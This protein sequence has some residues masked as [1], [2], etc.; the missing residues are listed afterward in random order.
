MPDF[1]F[2]GECFEA[3]TSAFQLVL[4]SC[5]LLPALPQRLNDNILTDSSSG[6]KHGNA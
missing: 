4:R 1:D 3:Y 6:I 2:L 5:I